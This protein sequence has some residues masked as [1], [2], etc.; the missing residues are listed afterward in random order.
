V[1]W[2]GPRLGG[3]SL[4]QPQLTGATVMLK[5]SKCL[6]GARRGTGV[7]GWKGC[8]TTPEVI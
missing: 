6:P 3:R 8:S 7:G 1:V 5:Q 4:L 2:N